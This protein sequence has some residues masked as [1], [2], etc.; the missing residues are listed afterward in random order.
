MIRGLL[1]LARVA[2]GSALV[3]AGARLLTPEIARELEALRPSREV[4][5]VVRKLGSVG[6]T[7][8]A[9]GML[10]NAKQHP[11]RLPEEVPEVP[12]VGSL[13]AQRRS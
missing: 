1:S 6:L 7:A 3:S 9:Q 5:P 2:L 11:R 12:L 10:D 4:P 8:K 13:A